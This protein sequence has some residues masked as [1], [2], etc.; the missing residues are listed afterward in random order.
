M[1][2]LFHRANQLN[3]VANSNLLGMKHFVPGI[4]VSFKGECKYNTQ[5][6]RNPKDLNKISFRLLKPIHSCVRGLQLPFYGMMA[7]QKKTIC[8]TLDW[9]IYSK[10]TQ[11]HNNYG[12]SFSWH[13]IFDSIFLLIKKSLLLNQV[14]SFFNQF[15]DC[16]T[17]EKVTP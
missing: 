13:H 5:R 14:A 4:S 3:V 10:N 7:G 9:V 16:K 6:I 12:Y 11:N 17:S 15:I 2:S 1:S 8:F